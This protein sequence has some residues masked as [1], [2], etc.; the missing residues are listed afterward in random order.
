MTDETL[1]AEQV[2]QLREE[3]AQLKA[4]VKQLLWKGW[5]QAAVYTIVGIVSAGFVLVSLIWLCWKG[6][7][8][9]ETN[10]CLI[11]QRSV[12]MPGYE[13]ERVVQWGTDRS[14]GVA[15]D[16][17]KAREI[18][19]IQGCQNIMPVENQTIRR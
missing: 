5:H 2:G 11:T 15:A 9:Y 14:L 13:I 17:D 12:V 7:N 19:R 10:Q 4:E 8:S 16:L 3:N 1:L 6:L 18:A